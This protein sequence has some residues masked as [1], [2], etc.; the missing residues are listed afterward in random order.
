[1]SNL[2]PFNAAPVAAGQLAVPAHILAAQQ[3]DESNISAGQSLPQLRF[4]GKTWSVDMGGENTVLTQSDGETPV[5]MV[6]VVIVDANAARSRAYYE[7]AFDPEKAAAPKCYSTDGVRP[8]ASVQEP[9]AT[10]CAACQM[11]KKGS[12]VSDNGKATVACA[13]FKRVAVIPSNDLTFEPLFLRLP[14]TS[15]WDANNSENEAKGWYAF[16]QYMK[17]LAERGSTHTKYVVTAIKFDVRE[18]YP[19]LLFKAEGWLDANDLATVNGVI[20]SKAAEITAILG[21]LAPAAVGSGAKALPAPAAAAAAEETE[22]A[23]PA[24]APAPA[25]KA[26]AK[27]KAATKPKP[28]PQVV[29]EDGGEGEGDAAAPAAKAPAA[30]NNSLASVLGGWDD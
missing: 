5:S 22:D 30:G 1:M 18:A 17:F 28:Q 27:P 21:G 19:K 8:D 11:S 2:I 16:D 14:Q 29:D 10:T 9:C 7:G 13:A 25:A 6:K 23:A 24:Q 20:E 3:E 15:I 12:K 26:A 4:K